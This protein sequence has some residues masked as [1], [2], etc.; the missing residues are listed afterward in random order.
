MTSITGVNATAEDME[1]N[2]S[3]KYREI[4]LGNYT[5]WMQTYMS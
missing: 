3:D 5:K 1:S 2:L 4:L